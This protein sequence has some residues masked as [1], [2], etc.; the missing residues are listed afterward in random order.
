M[1]SFT[2]N[3]KLVDENSV[4]GR[5]LRAYW[6]PVC[7]ITDIQDP[8]E[9]IRIKILDQDLVIFRM[10]NRKL[11]CIPENCPHRGA[12]LY[13]SF[14]SKDSI[15]CSY[16]GWEFDSKGVCINEPFE[17]DKNNNLTKCNV[18]PVCE[19]Y[20]LIF[21]YFGLGSPPLLPFIDVLE[22]ENNVIAWKHNPLKSNW[23]SIQ[24]NA[25]DVTH[26]YYLH[27]LMSLKINGYDSAGFSKPLASFG[28]LPFDMGV[29]KTWRYIMGDGFLVFG[30]GNPLVL[31]NLLI[32]ESEVHWRVPVDNIHT[33]IFIASSIPQDNSN[34]LNNMSKVRV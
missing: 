7:L 11:M 30:F 14:L 13:Y 29:I 32:L 6:H 12:S 9:K 15:T 28:F 1:S 16:H 5:L 17:N 4:S 19:R 27:G 18:Y 2:D 24:E 20:G 22:G 3:E 34:D 23:L 31:P 33:L 21:A 10:S 25:A 8:E 26:T